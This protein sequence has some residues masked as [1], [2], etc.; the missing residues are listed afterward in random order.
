MEK[1]QDDITEIRSAVKKNYSALQ[2][3]FA[4]DLTPMENIW[5]H[6][7]DVIYWKM[8]THQIRQGRKK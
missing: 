4:G 5:S 3:V 7:D 1:V 2:A 6:A 8:I